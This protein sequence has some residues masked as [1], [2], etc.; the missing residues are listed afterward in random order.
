MKD[1][2]IHH[3]V[4]LYWRS[5]VE[6]GETTNYVDT[7]PPTGSTNTIHQNKSASDRQTYWMLPDT[8]VLFDVL[9]FCKSISPNTDYY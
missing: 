3:A 1:K 5:A 4:F 9:I 7:A 6:A 2:E 8:F